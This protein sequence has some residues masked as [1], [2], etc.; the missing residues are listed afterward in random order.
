VRRITRDSLIRPLLAVATLVLAAC[1]SPGSYSGV[2]P[3]GE[4]PASNSRTS[5]NDS[6]K[7]TLY[8]SDSGTNEVE[9]FAW[10]KPKTASVLSGSFSEPQGM[11]ADGS[12]DVFITNTGDSNILEYAGSKLSNTLV[13]FGEY[14]VGCSYDTLHAILAVSNIIT[15]KD[16]AGN[17]AFYKDAKGTPQIVAV[18][19]LQRLYS[20]Q[21]DGSGDLFVSGENPSYGTA[22]A[23]MPAGSK[24]FKL[25][26]TQGF[27]GIQFV[28]GSLGWDGTYIVAGNQSGETVARIQNC[29]VVGTTQLLGSVDIVDFAISGNRLIAPDAGAAAVEIYPYPKGGDPIQVLTGF[30]EP[31]GAAVTS[32][33]KGT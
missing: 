31:I 12:G 10:P 7:A 20:I 26:C 18:P 14:P 23:E 25:I 5:F 30:S 21:Y 13:D 29:K 16:G 33:A 27:G 1:A 24:K 32:E 8:I 6:A 11:C 17:V 3:A 2:T 28:P 22:L 4:Q 9:T 19:G 15:T